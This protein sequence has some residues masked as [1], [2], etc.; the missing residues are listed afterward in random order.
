MHIF[1]IMTVVVLGAIILISIVG[2][3]MADAAG[4]GGLGVFLYLTP[5]WIFG[6]LWMLV[7]TVVTARHFIL[8]S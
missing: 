6:I 5:I 3:L 1:A 7:W 8:S 4:P 2:L